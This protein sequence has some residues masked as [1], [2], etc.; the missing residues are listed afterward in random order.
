MSVCKFL[1]LQGSFFGYN[2]SQAFTHQEYMRGVLNVLS[3]LFG[4]GNYFLEDF[5][6]IRI[7]E[8]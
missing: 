2:L 4:E 6:E 8:P 7:K 5:T 3:D 1:D